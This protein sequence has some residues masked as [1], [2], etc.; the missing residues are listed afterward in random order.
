MKKE[1]HL[2]ASLMTMTLLCSSLFGCAT[3]ESVDALDKRITAL[4]QKEKAKETANEARQ[5]LLETCVNI[6]ADQ[7][8]WDYIH[9]NG[10]PVAG[11][12]GTYTAPQ[13][14]WNEAEKQKKDK[15]EECKLLYGPR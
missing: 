2:Q 3:Q 14:Q 10:K 5:A 6:D 11:K 13:Y 7:V 15:I 9:L 1:N 12:P 8:Y 4:E